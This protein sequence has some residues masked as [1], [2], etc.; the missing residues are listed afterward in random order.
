MRSITAIQYRD[1]NT[2]WGTGNRHGNN[3]K[4]GWNNTRWKGKNSNR[5]G[6]NGKGGRNNSRNRWNNG[7][8]GWNN[9]KSGWSNSKSAWNNGKSGHGNNR[10]NRSYSSTYWPGPTE[11][12]TPPPTGDA[13]AP[14]Q[15]STPRSSLLQRSCSEGAA[16]REIVFVHCNVFFPS[17]YILQALRKHLEQA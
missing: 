4:G 13:E 16:K 9:S 14:S 15:A 11:D 8:S 12:D 5:Q 1:D 6:N 2:C 10:R 3:G 17:D 7:K